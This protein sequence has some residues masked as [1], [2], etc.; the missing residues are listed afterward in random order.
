MTSSVQVS[1]KQATTC[2]AGGIKAMNRVPFVMPKANA[3]FSCDSI[4]FDTS[5]GWRFVYRRMQAARGTEAQRRMAQDALNRLWHPRLKMF[6]LSDTG[7]AQ[8]G[9]Q[10]RW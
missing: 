6:C 10:M 9:K 1:I 2:F 5:I 3:A 8:S 4:L 7:S